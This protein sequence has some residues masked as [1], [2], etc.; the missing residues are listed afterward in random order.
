MRTDATRA[1]VGAALVLAL[2]GCSTDGAGGTGGSGKDAAK[3]SPAPSASPKPSKPV[4]DPRGTGEDRFVRPSDHTDL[5]AQP[6]PVKLSG[7]R[8]EVQG[9]VVTVPE[10]WRASAGPNRT[11]CLTRTTAKQAGCAAPELLRI[12]VMHP[13][14]YDMYDARQLTD[15]TAWQDAATPTCEPA[16]APRH[17]D[18]TS[19][20]DEVLTARTWRL[21]CPDPGAV[22]VA[23]WVHSGMYL[24]AVLHTTDHALVSDADKIVGAIDHRGYQA[25][26]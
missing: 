20:A 24:G 12:Y 4:T 1:L 18:L 5:P 22:T 23:R 26:H 16:T 9:L 2:A 8:V 13:Q 11:L 25:A 14:S 15:T 10:G 21:D 6:P 7:K 3:G 17:Q 19:R